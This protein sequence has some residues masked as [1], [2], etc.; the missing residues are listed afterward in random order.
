MENKMDGVKISVNK[1]GKVEKPAKK[2]GRP[3]K[4]VKKAVVKKASVA[5]ARTRSK[6]IK[7]KIDK[8]SKSSKKSGLMPM[9]ITVIITGVLVGGAIYAW[10][11]R[12]SEKNVNDV[13]K[14]AKEVREGFEQRLGQLKNK[15]TGVETENQ[16][17]KNSTKELEGR[18][19]LLDGAKKDFSDSEIGI[20]FEYPA[21]FGEVKIDMVDGTVGKK[22]KA[23]FSENESLVFGGATVDF[24]PKASTTK[25]NFLESLGYYTKKDKFYFQ[26]IGM[27][28]STEI[29]LVPTKKVG[30]NEDIL[31]VDKNS[32][33]TDGKADVAKVDIGDNIGAI[34]NLES[35]SFRGITFLDQDLS[36][37]SLESFE[38][39][40]AS[41]KVKE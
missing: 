7:K 4:V 6:A 24:K 10:Q 40:L 3:K 26:A 9:F 16:K 18:V 37:M 32:F 41:V 27:V 29:E 25:I 34:I 19:K 22:F 36:V 30:D 12:S 13:R 20:A 15:L 8:K 39:M 23:T 31:L 28:N 1:E 2:R 5:E 17:L 38:N 35:G 11:S 33:V 14:D 21:N